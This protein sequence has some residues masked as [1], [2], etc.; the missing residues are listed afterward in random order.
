MTSCGTEINNENNDPT[1]N[2]T[3]SIEEIDKKL[4]LLEN[5]KPSLDMSMKDPMVYDNKNDRWLRS[6]LNMIKQNTQ[7]TEGLNYSNPQANFK[8][9]RGYTA[10]NI[11]RKEK[12]T[13]IC[14]RMPK[15]LRRSE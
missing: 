5:R 13:E 15:A 7:P 4:K 6:H 14:N 9:Q 1:T 12:S 8:M 10:D 3:R 2:F 11:D